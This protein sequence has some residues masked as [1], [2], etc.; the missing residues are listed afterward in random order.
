MFLAHSL[1]LFH[2]KLGFLGQFPLLVDEDFPGLIHEGA[3]DHSTHLD[4]AVSSLELD[5]NLD[6]V[7]ELL[8]LEMLVSAFP[9][10]PN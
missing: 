4:H 5:Y 8:E 9:H 2:V 10:E 1:L 7:L 3:L 6:R